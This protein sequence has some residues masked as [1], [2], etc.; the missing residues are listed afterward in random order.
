MK[1]CDEFTGVYFLHKDLVC[2][3]VEHE[4]KTKS[5]LGLD[6]T[7]FPNFFAFPNRNRLHAEPGFGAAAERFGTPHGH[8]GR[9]AALAIDQFT[10][11]H[12]CDAKRPGTCGYAQ[13]RRFKAI[14]LYGQA[15]VRRVFS[16]SWE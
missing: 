15:G 4:K 1:R 6:M 3:A 10:E 13:P 2:Y 7:V 8:F 11:R 5:G 16:W 14:M 12:T 9:N